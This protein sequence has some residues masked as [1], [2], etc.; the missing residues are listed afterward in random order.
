[1][2]RRPPSRLAGPPVIP[3]L[4]P[5]VPAAR[6][7]S[8]ADVVAEGRPDGHEGCSHQRLEGR[9]PCA[10]RPRS[11]PRHP[12]LR[13]GTVGAREHLWGS[14]QGDRRASLARRENRV[15]RRTVGTTSVGRP[16][17]PALRRAA[18]PLL[19]TRCRLAPCARSRASWTELGARSCPCPHSPHAPSRTPPAM[20]AWPRAAA[21]FPVAT[22][23]L[24][25]G[26]H[27]PALRFE[28]AL[29]CSLRLW[30]AQQPPLEYPLRN[31]APA[32]V[33]EQSRRTAPSPPRSWHGG[34]PAHVFPP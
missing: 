31:R 7:A 17:R 5:S 32:A 24:R 23:A 18:P 20:R 14:A 16:V 26:L 25:R 29:H 13:C 10:A 30:G 3:A 15:V 4:R 21:R 11:R 9:Q 28:A 2:G 34:C 22:R 12:R 6:A 27:L 1:M 33:R 8:A 19:G